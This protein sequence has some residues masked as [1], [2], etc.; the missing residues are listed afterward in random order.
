L[1]EHADDRSAGGVDH[2]Y[3]DDL[4]AKR[5]ARH[6]HSVIPYRSRCTS[7]VGAVIA[8][9]PRVAVVVV[10][11]PARDH[12]SCQIRVGGIH[13]GVDDR[14]L[15]AHSRGAVPRRGS[16]DLAE[17]PLAAQ[18]RI[19][20]E[21]AGLQHPVQLRKF[22]MRIGAERIDHCDFVGRGRKLDH[23]NVDLF[24]M[25]YPLTSMRLQSLVQ[26]LVR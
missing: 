19:V 10:E 7:H 13:A 22:D 21:Q 1:S 9:V 5:D 24:E 26:L 17:M 23:V 15:H 11:V 2:L 25:K 6:T 20:D 4:G 16:T 18:G 14:N 12:G 8:Q 3:G